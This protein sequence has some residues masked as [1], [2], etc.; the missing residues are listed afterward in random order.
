MGGS[1]ARRLELTS[2]DGT[3]LG[4]EVRGEGSPLVLVHG[5]AVGKADWE[6]LPAV[7]AEHHTVWTYDRRGRGDSGDGDEA[8][9]GLEREV[10]DIHAVFAA[11]GDRAHLLA[12]SFGAVCA[13]EAAAEGLAPRSLTLYEPPVLVARV[14][15]AV[16]R[17]VSRY[18]T[19]DPD[20][21]LA[22][23][24]TEVAGMPTDEL[25]GFR[26]SD[27]W[28]RTVGRLKTVTRE[29]Q[30]LA[31]LTWQPGRFRSV[32]LPVL[33]VAGELTEGPAYPTRDDIAEALPHARHVT[34]PE[35]GH[36][37]FVADP[38]G[39]ARAVVDFTSAVEARGRGLYS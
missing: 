5:T 12:H 3:S 24:L 1:G 10:E 11:P 22:V 4:V 25:E 2:A 21:A 31:R 37:A 30:E 26:A 33:S 38:E 13:L 20:G 7:L 14:A 35:Q 15:D 18:E 6:R 39:F 36:V 17:C 29:I 23:F 34:I 19:G 27:D 32:T 9:Y 28:S 16:G 8:T